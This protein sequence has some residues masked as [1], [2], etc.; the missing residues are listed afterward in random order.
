M[1]GRGEGERKMG[2][3]KGKEK[4]MKV[5]KGEKKKGRKGEKEK[6]RRKKGEKQK[7]RKGEI[8]TRLKKGVICQERSKCQEKG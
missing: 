2:E 3:E 6:R 4:P 8:T 5:R 1:N 7:R